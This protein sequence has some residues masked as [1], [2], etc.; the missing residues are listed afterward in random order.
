MAEGNEKNCEEKE[1]AVLLSEGT[2]EGNTEI[3]LCGKYWL[4]LT[5]CFSKP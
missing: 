5:T 2:I 1:G 4:D 3:T